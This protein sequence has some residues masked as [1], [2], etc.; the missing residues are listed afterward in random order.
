MYSILLCFTFYTSLYF[1][2]L[3]LYLLPPLFRYYFTTRKEHLPLTFYTPLLLFIF[4]RS[5]YQSHPIFQFLLGQR[6]VRRKIL[7]R[8]HRLLISYQLPITLLPFHS[9]TITYRVASSHHAATPS[10]SFSFY[11]SLKH[12]TLVAQSKQA[13][14]NTAQADSRYCP[15]YSKDTS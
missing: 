4:T 3:L 15:L 6:V 2:S 13:S 9:S 8:L 12:N 10:F 1:A 5:P 14:Y 11:Q 7:Q